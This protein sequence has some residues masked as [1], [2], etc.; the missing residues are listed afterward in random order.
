[1]NDMTNYSISSNSHHSA[2][3]NK[4]MHYLKWRRGVTKPTGT[5]Y[6]FDKVWS[7]ALDGRLAVQHEEYKMKLKKKTFI[8][9]ILFSLFNNCYI[10][11]LAQEF[12]VIATINKM[13]IK[14]SKERMYQVTRESTIWLARAGKCLM[15]V[16]SNSEFPIVWFFLTSFAY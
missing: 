2:T 6:N 9:Y 10:Y 16:D 5:T 11:F 4:A 8:S 14:Q 7:G 15:T 12:V 3:A 1:M 13:I